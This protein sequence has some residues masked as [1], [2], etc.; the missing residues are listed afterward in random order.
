MRDNK[1]MKNKIYTQAEYE[2]QLEQEKVFI[3]VCFAATCYGLGL[4]L[5]YMGLL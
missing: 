1:S 2:K 5:L 3:N 4:I